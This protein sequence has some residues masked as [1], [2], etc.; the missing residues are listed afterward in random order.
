MHVNDLAL[1]TLLHSGGGPVTRT[2]VIVFLL[3]AGAIVLGAI[4]W[5]MME[6]L[7]KRT[8]GRNWPTARAVVEIVSVSFVEDSIPSPKPT[9]DDSYYRATLTYFYNSPERQMGDYSRTFADK[10]EAE[11]WANSYKG[12]TVNIHVDPRDPTRSV[13]KDEDL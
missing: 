8:R 7:I 11:A 3:A 4:S 5:G 10:Q 9:L 13:L 6:D 2:E 1:T 12:A